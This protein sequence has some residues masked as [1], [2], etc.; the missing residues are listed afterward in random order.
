MKKLP[1]PKFWKVIMKKSFLRKIS[2]A[3]KHSGETRVEFRG[4]WG[5]WDAQKTSLSFHL[6]NIVPTYEVEFTI[7]SYMLEFHFRLKYINYAANAWEIICLGFQDTAPPWDFSLPIEFLK[8]Y[9]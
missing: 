3:V 6:I 4:M 8:R 7:F 2:R 1:I 5:F 9:P